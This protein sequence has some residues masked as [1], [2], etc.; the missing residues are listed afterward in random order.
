[1]TDPVEG[2]RTWKLADLAEKQ[3]I[4]ALEAAFEDEQRVMEETTALKAQ[5]GSRMEEKPPEAS[6]DETPE[7]DQ[8]EEKTQ[9]STA[10]TASKPSKRPRGWDQLALLEKDVLVVLMAFRKVR[11]NCL[12]NQNSVSCSW[13]V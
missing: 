7:S 2:G 6:T 11:H 9:E 8:T 5:P 13:Q 1:M 3:D 10:A 4:E 12:N